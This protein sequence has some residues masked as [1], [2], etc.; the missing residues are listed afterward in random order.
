MSQ[1]I[2]LSFLHS[3]MQIDKERGGGEPDIQ[4]RTEH[5]PG[6]WASESLR[7]DLRSRTFKSRMYKRNEMKILCS[8]TNKH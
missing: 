8:K 4:Q 7:M 5:Q 3:Q 6:N 2:R 1:I